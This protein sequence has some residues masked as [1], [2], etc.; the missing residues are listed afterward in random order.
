MVFQKT[1]FRENHKGQKLHANKIYSKL[2]KEM[3]PK[4]PNFSHQPQDF[5]FWILTLTAISTIHTRTIILLLFCNL[6]GTTRVSRSKKVK[7]GR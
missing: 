3:K 7:P 4:V 5:N 6:S 1:Y 2:P